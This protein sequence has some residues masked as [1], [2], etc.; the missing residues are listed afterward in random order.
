[1][2]FMSWQQ[3]FPEQ[4]VLL[5]EKLLERETITHSTLRQLD[6]CYSLSSGNAEVDIRLSTVVS[7]FHCV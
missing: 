4:V 5:L 2:S 7:I 1:M 3:V 6:K